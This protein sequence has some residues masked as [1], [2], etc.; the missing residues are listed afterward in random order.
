MPTVSS[1]LAELK[2]KGS[3]KTRKIYG[4]HGMDP[5]RT[6]GVSVADLK[7]ITK[8]IRGRQELACELLS[9]GK[10]DAMYLAGMVADG[11]RVSTSQLNEWADTAAG[12]QMIFRVHHCLA[13][14]R[15]PPRPLDRA[16][17]DGFRQ[18]APRRFRMV[19]LLRAARHPA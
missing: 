19:H 5:A 17:V 2:E 18:G 10:M 16:R 6:F 11:S 15:E 12:L 4:K 7:V 1:I 14:G 3:D 13:G 9:T 8:S